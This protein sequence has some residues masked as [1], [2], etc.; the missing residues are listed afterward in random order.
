MI[1]RLQISFPLALFILL[2][3]LTFWL[4]RITR[5]PEQT[6]SDDWYSNP[7]YIVEE[8]SGI[9]MD[10][11]RMVK[12]QFTANK[13]FHYLTEDV[14]Q[15]E[16]ISFISADPKK[17]LLRLQADRAEIKNQGKNIYLTGDVIAMRG[18]DD[19]RG[20][21][22]LTTSFLHLIPEQNLVKTNQ[23]VTIS[24]LNAT[25]NA[26]GLELNNQTGMI[27]LMSRVKAINNK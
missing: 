8:L 20:K 22:T 9:R 4:D 21:T 17:P 13:L 19:E 18:A 10:H 1:S 15:M 6:K 25:I 26:V 7:D 27:Q 5:P 23:P 16:Q 2:M 14:T 11:D 12:R 24:K 3:F